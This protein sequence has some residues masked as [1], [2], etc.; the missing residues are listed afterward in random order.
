MKLNKWSIQELSEISINRKI[1]CF[2]AGMVA[3]HIGYVFHKY[4]I[5]KNVLF[6]VDSDEKKVGNEINIMGIK[7]PI[8]SVAELCNN[9]YKDVVVVIS[10]E[11]TTS[12]WDKLSNM[13]DVTVKDICAYE[14][15]NEKLMDDVVN[16]ES[17]QLT[18][19][20][21]YFIPPIIHYCW[22][23]KTTIPKEYKD[24]IEEWKI[25]CPQYEFCFW[26]ES[27]YD[28]NKCRYIK[29][30]YESGYYAFVTDYVRM[31]VIYQHGGIYLDTDVKLF[32]ELDALRNF[33]MFF[34]YGKWPAVASGCGFGASRKNAIIKELR[35][36]PRSHIGFVNE[37]GSFNK[38]T[39]CFYETEIL[40]KYGFKM[41]FTTQII[42]NKCILSPSFFVSREY[43]NRKGKP[44]KAIAAHM[45]AGSWKNYEI[46]GMFS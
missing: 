26:N 23:G 45:D 21:K 41:D 9:N 1:I 18:N 20:G 15:I 28:I 30:A 2:G 14:N 8:K 17:Y 44:A 22:F 5:W 33:E 27:N 13:Q 10:C 11:Q 29:E 37:D 4:D 3:Q 46:K 19:E 38:T 16:D 31:D 24:Y 12:V 40:Q 39:N 35:D 36:N 32:K 25:K 42:E 43:L 6:F 7:F 34:T